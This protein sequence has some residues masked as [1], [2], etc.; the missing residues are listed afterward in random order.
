MYFVKKSKLNFDNLPEDK[1]KR[2]VAEVEK[3]HKPKSV[4]AHWR[5][6]FPETPVALLK[7]FYFSK[8]EFEACC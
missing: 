3:A 7:L 4:L 8:K 5:T 6:N 1:A 2:L